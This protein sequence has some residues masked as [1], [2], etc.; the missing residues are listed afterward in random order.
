MKK[1]EIDKEEELKTLRRLLQHILT[2]HDI[3]AYQKAYIL[4]YLRRYIKDRGM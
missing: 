3:K 1:K 4:S 2:D